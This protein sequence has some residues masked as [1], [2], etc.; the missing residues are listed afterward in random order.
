MVINPRPLAGVSRV[1]DRVPAGCRDT[2][3]RRT[4]KVLQYS[5]TCIRL[6]SDQGKPTVPHVLNI[7]PTG[8]YRLSDVATDLD[9]SLRTLQRAVEAGRLAA[10]RAGRYTFDTGR[11]LLNWLEKCPDRRSKWA[12][13]P[14]LES[15]GLGAS[16]ARQRETHQGAESNE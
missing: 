15:L 1:P 11:S 9:V 13:G 7:R 10:A 6:S 16:G 8:V 4:P 5:C 3:R 14:E 12:G 2:V